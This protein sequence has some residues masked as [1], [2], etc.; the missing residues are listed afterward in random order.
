[1]FQPR[2]IQSSLSFR[3]K[4][5]SIDYVLVFSILILGIVSMFAM[6]STDG[7][8]FAYHTKSHILR[9]CIFFILFLLLSFVQIR[10]WHSTSYL[11]YIIFFILLLGV[12]YFGLTSSG[13][14]RWLNL[15]FMNLQPSEL[16]KVGLILFLA[17]YYHRVSLENVNKV[18][19]L[20]IPIV[21]LIAP[22][23]LVVMQPD[24]G[25]SLLIA[26]GGV[27][28]AWLAGVRAKFFAYMTL[29]FL[30]LLPVAISF[31][32]PYQKARILTFLNPE[33]DPLGAGYQ[34]IQSKIAVG[35]GGLF[36]KGFLN[37]SQSY[38]DY[39]PEKH[40]DFIFTLFSEEFGFAGSIFI[41]SIY[42][43]IISRIIKIGNV[44][45]SNFGK[46]YCYS[47]A[48]A[49][50]IYVVVNMGMVLGLLPIVGSPLPIMSYG[51]SSMMAIMFGLGIVMSCKVYKDTPVN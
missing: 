33:A 7:G 20:F 16:M 46:L 24:L 36:G 5:F 23:L 11:F 2:S 3:D 22:V 18:R 10:L 29:I 9:F 32:K 4:L 12:K 38:L 34:I 51:G 15:P 30:S 50:F 41:L 17:K 27:V 40:T 14:Q 42:G 44:T 25:T 26:A 47:F 28:V 8:T 45:R 19:F 31:L 49:F 6:Y 39:L 48:T 37:G 21:A 43:L 1:M 35:S 13:S